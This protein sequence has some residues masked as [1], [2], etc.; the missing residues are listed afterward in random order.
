MYRA[1]W[2]SFVTQS[3]GNTLDFTLG[4]LE[5]DAARLLAQGTKMKDL[6]VE[7]SM[8]NG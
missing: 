1:V 4:L 6:L 5:E 8:A 3:A 2:A 7:V